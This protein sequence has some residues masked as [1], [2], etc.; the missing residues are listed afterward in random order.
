MKKIN[1]PIIIGASQYTQRKKES[2]PL[3][4]LGLMVK[5]S[6]DAIENTQNKND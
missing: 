6:Q 4:P 1:N 2:H 3:D 5:T